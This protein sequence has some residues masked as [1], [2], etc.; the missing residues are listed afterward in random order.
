MDFGEKNLRSY[1]DYILMILPK[2]PWDPG[3]ILLCT[4]EFSTQQYNGNR[5]GTRIDFV[6][7]DKILVTQYISTCP[8][9]G[10]TD[11]LWEMSY[12]GRR[13]LFFQSEIEDRVIPL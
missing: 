1:E 10:E 4:E 7:G 5:E 6:P 9:N 12:W 11:H 2:A 3:D 8:V 13:V